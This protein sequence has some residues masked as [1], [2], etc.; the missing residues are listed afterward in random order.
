MKT[1]LIDTSVWVEYFKGSKTVAEIIHD[2]HST[3]Y[4]SSGRLSLS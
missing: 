2:K 3:Q 4:I 1:I